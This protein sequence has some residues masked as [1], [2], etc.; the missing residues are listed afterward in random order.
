MLQPDL[1]CLCA[2]SGSSSTSRVKRRCGLRSAGRSC[3]RP[4]RPSRTGSRCAACV[5]L[6]HDVA[7]SCLLLHRC[8]LLDL[9]FV[10]Q[11]QVGEG[12]ESFSVGQR[13]LLCLA[14]ALLKGAKVLIMDECTASV[15]MKT[16]SRIQQMVR[17]IF[18]D[19]TV[20]AI[21]CVDNRPS[22]LSSLLRNPPETILD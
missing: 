10:V 17:V 2:C 3:A 22:T 19:C 21:A 12:G 13:Q 14:R 7:R 8:I 11:A 15:D 5:P 1:P 16:D 18:K 6:A 9:T 20:L 4:S